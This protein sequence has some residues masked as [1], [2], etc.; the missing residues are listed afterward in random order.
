MNYGEYQFRQIDA[1]LCEAEDKRLQSKAERKREAIA[2]LLHASADAAGALLGCA[3]ALKLTHP[4]TAEIARE[5]GERLKLA[6]SL[7]AIVTEAV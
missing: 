3:D 5:A 6:M 4:R 1:E 7:A 2:A